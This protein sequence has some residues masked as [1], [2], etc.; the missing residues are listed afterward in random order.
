MPG[1]L[2]D[3]WKSG[4]VRSTLWKEVRRADAESAVSGAWLPKSNSAAAFQSQCRY[5]FRPKTENMNGFK[6]LQN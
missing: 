5:L 6:R 2:R 4:E 3:L 1:E